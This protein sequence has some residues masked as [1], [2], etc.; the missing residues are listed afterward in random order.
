MRRSSSIEHVVGNSYN[1]AG[2]LVDQQGVRADPDPDRAIGRRRQIVDGE[3]DQPVIPYPEGGRQEFAERP[4]V[5]I[6]AGGAP[7]GWGIEPA[8][9]ME[10]AVIVAEAA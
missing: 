3:I 6:P 7:V 10:A 4:A 8:R 5:L 1:F 9:H 2:V